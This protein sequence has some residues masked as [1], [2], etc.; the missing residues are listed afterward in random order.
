MCACRRKRFVNESSWSFAPAGTAGWVLIGCAAGLV[1]LALLRAALLRLYTRPLDRLIAV[2][3]RLRFARH[4]E[5]R[6]QAVQLSRRHDRLGE[7]ARTLVDMADDSRRR[8]V[9]LSTLLETGRKVASSL[10]LDEVF[11]NVLGQLETV[12]GVDACSIITLDQRDG[13]F[14][15]R[16]SRGLSAELETQR[17]DPGDQ[18]S[19]SM[20]ALRSNAPVQVAD[21]STDLAYTIGYR[22]QS[23]YHQFRSRLAI[24]LHTVYAPPAVLLLYKTE[25]YRYSYRELEL[26]SSLA[27]YAS[28]ALE[29]AALHARTDEQLH[30]QTSRLEAIVES[31]EDGLVLEDPHGDVLFCNRSAARLAGLSPI[32]TAGRPVDEL[33][34][35]LA[36]RAVEPAAAAAELAATC[37]GGDRDSVE[38]TLAGDGGGIDLRVQLFDVT[39]GSGQRIG[40]GQ[41][42]QD[43][44]ED[45]SLDRMKSALIA[46]VSHELRSPLA[47]IQGYASTLLAD[48]V[49]WSADEQLEFLSTIRTES[50]RLARLVQNLLDLSRIE[51]GALDVRREPQSINQI[52]RRAVSAFPAETLDRVSLDLASHLPLV[53]VDADRVEAVVRNLVDNAT[54][55]SPAGSPVDVT[56]ENGDAGVIVRVYDR[57]AGVPAAVAERIFEPFV[58][59]DIRLSRRVPGVGL[60]L[61]ICRGV[62]DAH[63][64]EMWM[65]PED[66]GTTFAFSLPLSGG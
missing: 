29:N 42:W 20:R 3:G 7:L 19:P 55:Y 50:D 28:I 11:D 21:T 30:D 53:D 62:V 65:T 44:S 23:S 58:R 66:P 33:L 8:V 41:L 1:A 37:N 22:R 10:K 16:A 36:R 49:S 12:F 26:A 32:E 4:S 27:G 5:E 56:T 47:L 38:L 59:A 2:S 35:L 9:E 63:G 51:A 46:T 24:P 14:L 60:G 25:P 31:L 34:A 13:V 6:D 18:H 54:K 15:V 52:V 57:G 40:R 17:I 45:R 43:V 39:D 64:G 48:D 61:S